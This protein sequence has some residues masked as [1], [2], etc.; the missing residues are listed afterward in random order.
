MPRVLVVDDA[1]FMRK[2]LSDILKR[3]GMEIAG[4]AEN[5][6]AAIDKF[7]ELKPDL[8]TLDVVMPK[9]GE[10]D[11][12]I[13]ALKEIMKI[14]ANAKVVMVS[15]MGQHALVVEAIQAGAKDFIVKPFQQARVAQA[16]KKV[17]TGEAA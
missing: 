7:K 3:E 14:D 2:V 12:G 10:I 15:A 5:G 4:E 16:I 9:V 1:L 13:S 6:Q 11:G 8:V 17:I